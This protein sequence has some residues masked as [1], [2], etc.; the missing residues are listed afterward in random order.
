M[1]AGAPTLAAWREAAAGHP[2]ESVGARLRALMP[3]LRDGP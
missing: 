3:W 1:A 2:L